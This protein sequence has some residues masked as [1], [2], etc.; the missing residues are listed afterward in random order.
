MCK[1]TGVKGTVYT[2]YHK[3]VYSVIES[4]ASNQQNK[5]VAFLL[6]RK[7]RRLENGSGETTGDAKKRDK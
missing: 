7:G 3:T 5:L 4:R 6:Y 2:K 1:K